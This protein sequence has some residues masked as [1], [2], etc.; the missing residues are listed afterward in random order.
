MQKVSIAI[1]LSRIAQKSQTLPIN[2]PKTLTF[3]LS[4][5]FTKVNKLTLLSLAVLIC[6]IAGCKKDPTPT[7]GTGNQGTGVVEEVMPIGEEA[8]LTGDSDY[9]FD[10]EVLHRFDLIVSTTNMEILDNDPTAE[11]YVE[12][13]LVF[14]GD[15]LS[16]VGLRYKGSIGGFVGCVDGPFWWNP[17]GAK[18]CPK[19]SMK[20]KI[21]WAGRTDRFYGQKKIQLHS[22]NSDPTQFHDR[23]GYHLYREMGVPAPRST[24]AQLYINGDYVGLFALI[25]QIDGRFTDYHYDDGDGNLYKEVW[26]VTC[27]GKARSEAQLLNGLKT[28][29]NDNPS[30][31]IT[32]TFAQ[33]IVDAET[34][35]DLRSIILEWMDVDEIMAYVAV[36]RAIRADD[37]AFHWYVNGG[38]CNPHNFYWY[39]R[40][41][42]GKVSL[43]PWDM[44]NSFDNII[45]GTNSIINI[46]DDWGEVS[47]DC[48]PFTTGGFFGIEQRS[49]ACDRLTYAWTLFTDE[50]QD[51]QDRL[52]VGPFA[53][54]NTDQLIDQWSAQ[55]REA[56]Q[57]AR[58]KHGG[59]ALSIGEWESAVEVLK[60]RLDIARGKL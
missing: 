35:T 18:T 55:I 56:T 17:S 11:E 38:D 25:E 50:Y 23:L 6:S 27:D 14:E 37:G 51:Q 47:N 2:Y 9:L 30:A 42:D 53:Q 48:E 5:A 43:I 36:D 32:H 21:N 45:D 29:E 12:A 40:P 52:K 39:E 8:Y 54:A 3:K 46:P 34:D 57:E 33:A 59:D 13:K 41:T 49:A 10:Q 58:Q 26:P 1:Q 22:M 24:H 4:Q 60:S 44:D 16:P 7:T 31:V 20:L 15:T 28:N 19:L